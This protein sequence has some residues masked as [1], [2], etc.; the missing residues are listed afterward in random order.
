[1]PS[2]WTQLRAALDPIA[3][4]YNLYT[5]YRVEW[6]EHVGTVDGMDVETARWFL[7]DVG[8]VP[9]FLS[10]AKAWPE[11][12][13]PWSNDDLHDLSY[14]R[15]PE[16]HPS[17]AYDTELEYWPSGLCQYHV[18]VFVRDGVAY[19]FSHYELRP[20]FLRPYPS[21]PRLR[22]HYRPTYGETYLRGV[23]DLEL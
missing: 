23:T 2:A 10:A 21:I 7:D 4:R 22:E 14:R 18:H 6:P 9:Q 16:R 5:A 20:D 15:V 19:F 11:S 3:R 8:Y 17:E 13:Q 12:E 1:M